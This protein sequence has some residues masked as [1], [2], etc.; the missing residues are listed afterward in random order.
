MCWT[1]P[2]TRGDGPGLTA[3]ASHAVTHLT[4]V[5]VHACDDDD[6]DSARSVHRTRSKTRVGAQ[7]ERIL[8][9]RPFMRCFTCAQCVLRALMWSNC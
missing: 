5:R 3:L 2:Q 6:D 7:E 8:N 9:E 4:E 1:P